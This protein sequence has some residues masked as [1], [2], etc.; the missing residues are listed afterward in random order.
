MRASG[1]NNARKRSK[2]RVRALD[3]HAANAISETVDEVHQAGVEN[4]KEMTQKRSGRLLRFYKKATRGKGQGFRGLVGYLT[5]TAR[6]KAFHA[7]FIHDGTKTVE[8]RPY[9]D[10]AV[11]EHEG[12]HAGRMRA[13]LAG[14]LSNK[15][16]PSAL[17]RTGG[18]SER[19]LE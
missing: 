19:D 15:A 7:R 2:Q 8:A 5:K 11:L 3:V 1:F 14:A 17:A 6:R 12:K 9:H 18:G 13:A 4:I 16:A 10:N